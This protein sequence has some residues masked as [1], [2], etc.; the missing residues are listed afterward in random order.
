MIT[1]SNGAQ[2]VDGEGTMGTTEI[3]IGLQFQL[4]SKKDQSSGWRLKE[5]GIRANG[6]NNLPLQSESGQENI[7]AIEWLSSSIVHDLRNPLGTI[8][9]AAEMLMDLDLGPTPGEA[10]FDQ[11]LSRSRSHAGIT[12]RPQQRCPWKQTNG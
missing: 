12:G 7:S 11:Y 10:A 8:Y 5:R 9:A 3:L 2:N 6:M 1:V 4:L